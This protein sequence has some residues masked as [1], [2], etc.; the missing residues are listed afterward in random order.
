MAWLAPIG[1]RSSA[2]RAPAPPNLRQAAGLRRARTGTDPLMMNV[3]H[4]RHSRD[5]PVS[6]SEA[7]VQEPVLAEQVG[8]GPGGVV[9]REHGVARPHR[10]R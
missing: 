2:E 4:D 7:V 9:Q 6:M 3:G 1:V 10:G 8:R 5:L